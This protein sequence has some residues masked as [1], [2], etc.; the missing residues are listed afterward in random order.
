MIGPSRLFSGR[1][2]VKKTNIEVRIEKKRDDNASLAVKIRG[3]NRK[4][5][6]TLAT[7]TMKL[8]PNIYMERVSLG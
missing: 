4:S 1:K 8:V 5:I 7:V 2:K 3:S 6:L